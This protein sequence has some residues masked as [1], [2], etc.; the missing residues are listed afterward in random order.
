MNSSDKITIRKA[1]FFINL[2]RLPGE[3]YFSTLREK[4]LWGID[5]RN[6]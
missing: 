4:L 3:S 6:Y 1:P 2:I 5:V